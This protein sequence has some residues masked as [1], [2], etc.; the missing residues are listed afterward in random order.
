MS[1][2]LLSLSFSRRRRLCRL[3]GPDD[4]RQLLVPLHAVLLAP[5]GDTRGDLLPATGAQGR[6]IGLEGLLQESLLVW[7]PWGDVEALDLGG[8]LSAG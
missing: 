3:L 4:L 2:V 6:R 1:I 8:A 7:G 5:V